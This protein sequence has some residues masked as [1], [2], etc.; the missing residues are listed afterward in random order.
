MHMI[1]L[2]IYAAVTGKKVVWKVCPCGRTFPS[3]DERVVWHSNRC[4]RKHDS[5]FRGRVF[6]FGKSGVLLLLRIL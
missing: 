5:N 4:R 1:S 2:Q 3:L 6:R